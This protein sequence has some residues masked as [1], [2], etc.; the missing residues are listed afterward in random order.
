MHK[1]G[2]TAGNHT[3]ES[4]PHP[5]NDDAAERDQK[6]DERSLA[7]AFLLQSSDQATTYRTEQC[8][9]CS[10]HYQLFGE[11]SQQAG[12][13]SAE[14]AHQDIEQ[15]TPHG[16]GVALVHV[17]V[18]FRAHAHGGSDGRKIQRESTKGG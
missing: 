16:S 11:S 2:Q 15:T 18:C 10:G 14:D 5:R 9:T 6:G 8:Q 12:N 7:A 13:H 1:Q 17:V 4:R 3:P